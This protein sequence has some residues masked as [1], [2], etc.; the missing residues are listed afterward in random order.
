[1]LRVSQV[2]VNVAHYNEACHWSTEILGYVRRQ[3]ETYADR[4]RWLTVFSPDQLELT[5]DQRPQ[6][7]ADSGIGKSPVFVIQT[8]DCVASFENLK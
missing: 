6:S 7:S 5:L 4:T 1:M 3:D 2:T 8:D